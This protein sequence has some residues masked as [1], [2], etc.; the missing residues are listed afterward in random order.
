VGTVQVTMGAS[1]YVGLACSATLNEAAVQT[2]FDQ[3]RL[4]SQPNGPAEGFGLVDGSVVAGRAKKL[5]DEVLEYTDSAGLKRRWPA[6]EIAYLFTRPLPPDLRHA[7]AKGQQKV[8]LLSGDEI[9][10]SVGGLSGGNMTV[11]SV[12]FGRKTEQFSKL[13]AV[14]LR[15]AQP[16]GGFALITRDG[17]VYR[18]IKVKADEGFLSTE[19]RSAGTLTVQAADLVE[20]RR[21]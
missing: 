17:S 2:T 5:D 20:V 13:Q 4:A 9:E 19:S 16:S 21:D 1:G 8:C 15:P 10:G 18:C 7:L 14:C 12:L 3:V 6:R 11:D